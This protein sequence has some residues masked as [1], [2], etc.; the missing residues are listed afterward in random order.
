MFIFRDKN[1]NLYG[2]YDTLKTYYVTPLNIEDKKKYNHPTVTPLNINKNFI[3][4]SSKEN[5]VVLDPFMGSGTTGE[6]AVSLKRH[7]IGLEIDSKYFSTAK[8]E[9]N[10]ALFRKA[11]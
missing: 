3:I 1:V 4:N 5:E 11:I 8:K 2:N 10:F 9:L 7:F 6:A